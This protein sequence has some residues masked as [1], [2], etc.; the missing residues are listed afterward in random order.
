[1][2]L[3]TVLSSSFDPGEMFNLIADFRKAL[4]DQLPL[5]NEEGR[6]VYRYVHRLCHSENPFSIML[7]HFL[8]HRYE[9]IVSHILGQ[10]IPEICDLVH[11]Q[12]PEDTQNLSG[13][14]WALAIDSRKEVEK[15]RLFALDRFLSHVVS[16]FMFNPGFLPV[17]IQG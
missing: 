3:T 7:E 11:S 6:N 4:N 10:S 12:E 17:N 1:M 5:C 15:I 14:L 9:N 16:R 2:S 13:W 8:N